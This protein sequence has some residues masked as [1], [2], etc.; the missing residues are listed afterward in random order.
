MVGYRCA[1]EAPPGAGITTRDLNRPRNPW[2]AVWPLVRWKLLNVP[3]VELTLQC[4][5]R[6]PEPWLPPERHRELVPRL[7]PLPPLLPPA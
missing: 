2:T 5:A 7:P 6:L 3:E 1:G 4:I